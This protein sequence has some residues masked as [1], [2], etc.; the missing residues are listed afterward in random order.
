MCAEIL[1]ALGEIRTVFQM[2][3]TQARANYDFQFAMKAQLQQVVRAIEVRPLPMSPTDL[4]CY[5]HRLASSRQ[6]RA[7]PSA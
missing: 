6:R 2:L 4:T 7:T 5:T 3:A 1:G